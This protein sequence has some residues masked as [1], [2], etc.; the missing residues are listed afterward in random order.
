MG[1]ECPICHG[2][3]ITHLRTA[4]GEP[5]RCG[6]CAGTGDLAPDD[7][8]RERQAAAN[9]WA[10]LLVTMIVGTSFWQLFRPAR[11]ATIRYI[12]QRSW[13]AR[14]SPWGIEVK[15]KPGCRYGT[16]DRVEGGFDLWHDGDCPARN[17]PEGT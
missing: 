10:S 9:A 3:G 8:H 17:S 7:D 5:Q 6:V 2:R 13:R 15:C 14:T 12:A 16:P 4:S 1:R 11:W